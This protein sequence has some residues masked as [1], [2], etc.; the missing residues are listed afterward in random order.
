MSDFQVLVFSLTCYKLASLF[1]GTVFSFLGYRLFVSGIDER[2]GELKTTWGKKSLVLK[3]AAPGTFFALFGVVLI[4]TTLIKGL[5]IEQIKTATTSTNPPKSEF[6]NKLDPE[7]RAVF[8]K[9]LG[10]ETLD[11]KEKQILRAYLIEQKILTE[12]KMAGAA[13]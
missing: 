13:H 3:Q 4:S 12:S 8:S 1:I 2:A 6:M 5:D 9:F 11:E 10:G 7:E